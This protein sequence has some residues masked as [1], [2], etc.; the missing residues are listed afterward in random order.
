MKQ[1][2]FCENDATYLVNE[3]IPICSTC[4]D[5]YERG[6]KNPSAT[7]DR[8]DLYHEQLQEEIES[9][10]QLKNTY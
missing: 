2:H 7:I 9:L 5:V 8:I 4:K 10:E 6:Q 3:K 1:C